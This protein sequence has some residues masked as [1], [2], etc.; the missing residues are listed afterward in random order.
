M[1]LLLVLTLSCISLQLLSCTSINKTEQ[2]VEMPVEYFLNYKQKD[3]L[4]NEEKTAS[5][6]LKEEILEGVQNELQETKKKLKE[7]EAEYKSLQA[8]NDE[9]EFEFQEIKD[10]HTK[11]AVQN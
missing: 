3:I 8:E 1:R 5:N 9:F 7:L 10:K 11:N 6:E 4:K 2:Q